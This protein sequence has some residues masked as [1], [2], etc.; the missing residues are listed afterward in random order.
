MPSRAVWAKYTDEQRA[1]SR[2][3]SDARSRS[4]KQAHPERVREYMRRYRAAAKLRRSEALGQGTVNS[5]RP[6]E[7]VTGTNHDCHN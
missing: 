2:A 6:V 4:W 3:A 7:A 1:K 5:E